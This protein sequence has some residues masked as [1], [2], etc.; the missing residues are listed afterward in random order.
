MN[1]DIRPFVPG[2]EYEIYRLIKRVYGEF[3]SADCTEEG[4][5]FFYDWIAPEYIARRQHGQNNLFVTT[6][7]S[8][9]VGMI[10]TRDDQNITLMFVD[11]EH[12]G[13]GIAR[14][15]FEKTLENCRKRNKSLKK[16]YVHASPYS[17]QVY[18]K[19][20]FVAT[21]V[22]QEE[23]GIQYLPMEKDLEDSMK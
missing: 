9:I 3:V 19:L 4:N 18:E 16:F 11:K 8:G 5:K 13:R 17:V 15:L 22:M 14:K 23:H 6:E 7:T 2:D 12:Q 10:E 21:N 1:F 20:G